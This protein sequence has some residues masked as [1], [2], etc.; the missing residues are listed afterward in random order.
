MLNS[1]CITLH[2]ASYLDIYNS[3]SSEDQPKSDDDDNESISDNSLNIKSLIT[4]HYRSGDMLDSS[5]KSSIVESS[6]RASS[7]VDNTE[8][9]ENMKTSKDVT[10]SRRS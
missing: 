6:A 4:S 3:S 7:N 2:K 9:S 8:E 1:N 5:T 10:E